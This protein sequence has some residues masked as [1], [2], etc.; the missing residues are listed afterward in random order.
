[1]SGELAENRF[2]S[3]GEKALPE[4]EGKILAFEGDLSQ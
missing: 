2:E 3:R 1:M 4:C